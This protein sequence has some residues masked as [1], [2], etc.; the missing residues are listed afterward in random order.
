MTDEEFTFMRDSDGKGVALSIRDQFHRR[1]QAHRVATDK[2]R[3]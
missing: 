2:S 1:M 3:F